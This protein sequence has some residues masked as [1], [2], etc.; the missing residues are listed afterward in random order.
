MYDGDRDRAKERISPSD[1]AQI[2]ISLQ[3][4]LRQINQIAQHA[5]LN[6]KKADPV[7]SLQ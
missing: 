4:A 7:A 1:H 2:T 6:N 3:D 5:L